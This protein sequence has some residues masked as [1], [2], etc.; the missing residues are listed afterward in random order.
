MISGPAT[1]RLSTS[2]RTLAVS[3]WS[4]ATTASFNGLTNRISSA[5]TASPASVSA[6]AGSG[7]RA[8]SSSAG[9]MQLLRLDLSL[10]VGARVDG[11]GR[12]DLVADPRQRVGAE[13]TRDVDHADPRPGDALARDEDEVRV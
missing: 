3:P 6:T 4:A 12:A 9:N 2:S 10:P 11:S 7:G 13:L 1:P 8:R 5:T